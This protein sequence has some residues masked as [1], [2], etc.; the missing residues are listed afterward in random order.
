M[1]EGKAGFF[2]AP[3]DAD[4]QQAGLGFW[5]YGRLSDRWLGVSRDFLKAATGQGRRR[6][7]GALSHLE[8]K[9]TAASGAAIATFYVDGVLACSC[10]WVSGTSPNAERE[11]VQL[12]VASVV[13]MAREVHSE[14]AG[15]RLSAIDALVQRPLAVFVIWAPKVVSDADVALVRE[16][17]LHVAAALFQGG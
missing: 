11:V 10:L 7:E 14:E 4:G 2:V 5:E 3:F 8:T 16:L 12:F 13:T 17:S 6:W 15:Q 1:L 9:V